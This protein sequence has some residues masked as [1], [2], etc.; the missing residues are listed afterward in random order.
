[1]LKE[2]QQAVKNAV[3]GIGSI[4]GNVAKGAES[5]IESTAKGIPGELQDFLMS[6]KVTRIFSSEG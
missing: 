6:S 5:A 1:V 2:R 4:V 3:K